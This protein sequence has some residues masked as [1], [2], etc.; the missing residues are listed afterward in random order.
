MLT[1]VSLV[2][3]A[4][5]I[6]FTVRK[7]NKQI[8]QITSNRDYILMGHETAM[9]AC[10]QA[11]SMATNKVEIE[12]HFD[13]Q[14]RVGNLIKESPEGFEGTGM[15]RSQGLMQILVW[16]EIMKAYRSEV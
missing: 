5:A 14:I 10:V 9:S 2:F 4:L 13:K 3:M 16:T 11:I 1:S 6:V 15:T 7:K 12:A 8:K